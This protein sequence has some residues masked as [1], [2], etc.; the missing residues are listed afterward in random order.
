[1]CDIHGCADHSHLP[2]PQVADADRRAFMAG[3]V[4]LPLAAVLAYPE[5][6]QAAAHAVPMVTLTGA[7]GTEFSGAL[8]MPEKATN[9][10]AM[11]LIHEWWGLNDHIKAVAKDFADLGYIAFAIDLHGGEVAQTPPE[12]MGLMR[13]LNPELATKQLVA[14]IE[15]LRGHEASNGKVGTIGWCFGG[16]WSLNA[17]LATPVDATVVYY[18]SVAKTADEVGRAAAE[19]MLDAYVRPPM[20]EET[21]GALAAFVDKQRAEYAS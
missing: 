2:L 5:L 20:A 3:A 1:M 13:K 18:G 15:H 14:A 16:G 8:A 6:T 11:V 12:A 10:P 7:D 4:T 19:K 17:S 21:R 9:A